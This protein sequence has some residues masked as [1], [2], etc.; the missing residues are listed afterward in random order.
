M[1]SVLSILCIALTSFCLYSHTV[2]MLST[3]YSLP[4]T[5]F[6]LSSNHNIVYADIHWHCFACIFHYRLTV[7][8]SGISL[9][10]FSAWFRGILHQLLNIVV[11]L[12]S[13]LKDH[14]MLLSQVFIDFLASCQPRKYVLDED[15]QLHPLDEE[16]GLIRRPM[17]CRIL[18]EVLAAVIPLLPESPKI[19]VL[20]GASSV[21]L[22]LCLWIGKRKLV[23][24]SKRV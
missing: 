12:W 16:C 1:Y 20:A 4:L 15:L 21:T 5:A 22:L 7:T 8:L 6:C 3:A 14:K 11:R 24:K 17:L 2:V 18:L 13:A 23:T 19:Q 10:C 9:C